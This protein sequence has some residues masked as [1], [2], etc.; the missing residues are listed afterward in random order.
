MSTTF[1]SSP[2]QWQGADERFPEGRLGARFGPLVVST[3]NASVMYAPLYDQDITVRMRKGYHFGLHDPF[4]HP[5]PHHGPTR[6]LMCVPAPTK[7]GENAI[8][9]L[10]LRERKEWEP[11]YGDGAVTGLGSIIPE[12]VDALVKRGTQLVDEVDMFSEDITAGRIPGVQAEVPNERVK[13]FKW[14]LKFYLR[15]VAQEGSFDDC[16][17]RWSCARRLQL[18][19][20]AYIKYFR[21]YRALF[22]DLPLIPRP[23]DDTLMGCITNNYVVA[24]EV[25]TV[26]LPVWFVYKGLGCRPT[27][28]RRFLNEKETQDI[29]HASFIPPRPVQMGSSP[30]S[31]HRFLSLRHHPLALLLWQG[32]ADD[33]RRFTVMT[34]VFRGEKQAVSSRLPPVAPILSSRSTSASTS[35]SALTA[36]STSTAHHT[37][38]SAPVAAQAS[39]K[40]TRVDSSGGLSHKKA[41]KTRAMGSNSQGASQ[42]EPQAA[43]ARSR[44]DEP[45][46]Q[47]QLLPA[48]I[49][50]ILRAQASV[51]QELNMHPNARAIMAKLPGLDPHYSGFVVPD[52]SQ[53]ASMTMSA[54]QA[55]AIV[56]SIR[57]RTLWHYRARSIMSPV[58]SVELVKAQVWRSVIGLDVLGFRTAQDDSPT[59]STAQDKKPTTSKR[60]GQSAQDKRDAALD[61]LNKTM[62]ASGIQ[63]S[64]EPGDVRKSRAVWQGVT[65]EYNTTLPSRY[66]CRSVLWELY[67]LNFRSEFLLADFFLYDWDREAQKP[68]SKEISPG[69]RRL[70]LCE[71]MEY[72]DGDVVPEDSLYG[73]EPTGFA[74][75][76]RASHARATLSFLRAMSS[77]TGIGQVPEGLEDEAT[78]IEAEGQQATDAMVDAWEEAVWQHYIKAY[79]KLFGRPPTVPRIMPAR[80]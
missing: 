21:T 49:R 33:P 3:P 48:P 31:D 63:M 18:E 30:S 9:F 45:L 28:F 20:C 52:G 25:Y 19:I 14:Y 46:D 79:F 11:R 8:L 43:A 36:A 59:T 26:G 76:H 6:Y 13:K 68:A 42:S 22:H 54:T 58:Y 75:P 38:P 70:L 1:Q 15:T 10:G 17:L 69:E 71:W 35:A 5:Q 51:K 74:S 12:L 61:A 62:E 66:I 72:W 64:L 7:T 73:A 78:R 40:R 16:E 37:T 27:D 23:T 67:E 2:P 4:S 24:T 55:G 60:H 41:K 65:I 34:Q 29:M 50:V 80:D 47:Q 44:F 39:S 77:W 56:N 32:K 57:F 53:I